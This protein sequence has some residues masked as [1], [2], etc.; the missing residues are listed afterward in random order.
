MEIRS[1]P[2]HVEM[3]TLTTTKFNFAVFC[4]YCVL[5]RICQNKERALCLAKLGRHMA[6]TFI[7]KDVHEVV[8]L[9]IYQSW[10]QQQ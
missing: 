5:D 9:W 2:I 7:M 10:R 3:D 4:L 6:Y 8:S 1:N